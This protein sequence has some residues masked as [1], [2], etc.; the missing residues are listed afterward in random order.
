MAHTTG[1]FFFVFSLL[2]IGVLGVFSVILAACEL[3][4]LPWRRQRG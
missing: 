4:R 2:A 1:H 3:W